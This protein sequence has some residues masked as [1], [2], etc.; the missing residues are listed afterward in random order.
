MTDPAA[1]NLQVYYA[2]DKARFTGGDTPSR[3]LDW[4]SKNSQ[5]RALAPLQGTKLQG[6]NNASALT[7]ELVVDPGDGDDRAHL[8]FVGHTDTNGADR[9]RL[10]LVLNDLQHPRLY[11]N[12]QVI[13]RLNE[14]LESVGRTVLHFVVNT[15][16]ADTDPA[17]KD[18][19]KLRI[20]RNGM[21]KEVT[22]ISNDAAPGGPLT[23]GDATALVLGNALSEPLSI[24]GT[25]HYAAIYPRALTPAQVSN[26][27]TK[28]R[29]LNDEP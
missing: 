6:L 21:E 3:G 26:H 29:D 15:E 9:T 24:R 23:L 20:F 27:A 28:L 7:L 5:A 10:G 8:L 22:R 4:T 25:I 14:N 11:W 13:G 18:D 19:N 12:E 2:F 16:L 17:T 1:V